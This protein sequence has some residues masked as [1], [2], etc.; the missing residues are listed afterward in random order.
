MSSILCSRD[1]QELG[2]FEAWQVRWFHCSVFYIKWFS[3]FLVSPNDVYALVEKNS[4]QAK[5]MLLTL[6]ESQ[7]DLLSRLV[8]LGL[9]GHLWNSVLNS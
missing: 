4:L 7:V 1:I 9:C 5:H 8:Q 6:K 3:S 2:V